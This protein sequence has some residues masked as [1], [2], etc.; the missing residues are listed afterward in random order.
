MHI[1][2][3]VDG[4]YRETIVRHTYEDSYTL[5]F[6][7]LHALITE[8]RPVKTGSEDAKADLEIFKMIMQEGMKAEFMTDSVRRK[9]MNGTNGT[10]MAA[11]SSNCK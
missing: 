10:K 9:V 3:N 8:G 6:K 2:E 1:A 5:E 4:S 7:E 11:A